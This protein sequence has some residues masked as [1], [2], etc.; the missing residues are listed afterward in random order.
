MEKDPARRHQSIEEMVG[1]LQGVMDGRIEVQCQRTLI[2]RGLHELLH[3]VDQHPVAV[4]A[5]STAAAAVVLAALGHLLMAL[6]G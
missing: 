6:L 5:G 2:K 3:K 1:S 4:M